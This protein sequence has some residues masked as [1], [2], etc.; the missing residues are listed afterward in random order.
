MRNLAGWL[1]LSLVFGV[2]LP[3]VHADQRNVVPTPQND[4]DGDLVV[5]TADIDDDNDGIP[6]QL[7]IAGNGDDVDSDSDGLPDR[8]DLDSDN[9]GILDWQESGALIQLDLASLRRV[10]PRLVGEVGTN[11]MI[12]LFETSVDSDQLSY[13][14]S[15]RDEEQDSVPDFLDLDSDNDGWPDLREAGVSS[16][17]DTDHDGRLDL[18]EASV[19]TDGIADYLQWS[20]EQSCCD[21]DG[22]GNQEPSPLNTDLTDLPDFQDLDSD[23]DGTFDLVELGGTDSDGDGRVDN[24]LDVTGGLD[25]PDGMDDGLVAFPLRPVDENGN[26]VDDHIEYVSGSVDVGPDSAGGDSQGQ[27]PG[28]AMPDEPVTVPTVPSAD[29]SSSGLVKTGLS[30]SG[31]S[32]YSSTSGI[33]MWALLALSLSQIAGRRSRVRNRVK[34]VRHL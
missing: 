32:I 12:D 16:D 17:Y 11:G 28:Q 15:N 6:D 20:S 14:L 19:G 10:G 22:D 33:V 13:S 9:D 5:N 21:L 25:G 3:H 34:P 7:E 8:L 31:C 4:F 24:F 23:N 2:Q 1:I 30:S 26:G 29:Q 18:T 27:Q